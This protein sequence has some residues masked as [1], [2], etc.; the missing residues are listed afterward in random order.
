MVLLSV[1]VVTNSSSSIF[2]SNM[3]P[4]NHPKKSV[5]VHEALRMDVPHHLVLKKVKYRVQT[6]G[7]NYTDM[8]ELVADLFSPCCSMEDQEVPME[9]NQLED[10]LMMHSVVVEMAL[11]AL[12]Q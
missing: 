9:T 8:K 1:T 7:T 12:Q 4:G 2:P 3:L 10:A 11:L 6:H 5:I